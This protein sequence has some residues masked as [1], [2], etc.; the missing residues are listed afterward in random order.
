MERLVFFPSRRIEQLSFG[1]ATCCILHYLGHLGTHI[2]R[3]P[4]SHASGDA[5]I[6]ADG[7]EN[8]LSADLACEGNLGMG[9]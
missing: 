4:L 9:I 8:E 3:K 6:M 5:Y 1:S 2:H 7:T